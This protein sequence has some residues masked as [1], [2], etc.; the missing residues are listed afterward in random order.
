LPPHSLAASTVT[1]L[2]GVV[3]LNDK[4]SLPVLVAV[5]T[6]QVKHSR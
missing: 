3:V 4:Q 6:N 2:P 5:T 1:A